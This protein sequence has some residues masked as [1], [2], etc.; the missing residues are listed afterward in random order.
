[1]VE[2]RSSAVNV[3]RNSRSISKVSEMRHGKDSSVVGA[4]SE[5]AELRLNRKLTD[6]ESNNLIEAIN[7]RG[8]MPVWSDIR[9]AQDISAY[10]QGLGK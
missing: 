7:K 3:Q 1:M 8:G 2:D 9:K 10:L 4:I 6:E 5:T